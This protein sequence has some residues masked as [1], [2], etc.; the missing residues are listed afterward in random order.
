MAI[1]VGIFAMSGGG[2]S[3]S[4]I[5]NPDGKYDPAN[6]QA[7]DLS[8]VIYFNADKKKP[9]FKSTQLVTGVNYF[10]TSDS[11]IILSTIKAVSEKGYLFKAIQV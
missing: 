5:I 7:M 10:E 3:T 2:K 9:P 4:L 1:T 11:N 6:Y 8:K